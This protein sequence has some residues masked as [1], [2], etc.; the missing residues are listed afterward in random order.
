MKSRIPLLSAIYIFGHMPLAAAITDLLSGFRTH[1]VT[2]L[3]FSGY[4]LFTGFAALPV[5]GFLVIRALILS[6]R[7]DARSKKWL[8]RVPAVVSFG[9]GLSASVFAF[10][11]LPTDAQAAIVFLFLPMYVLFAE[12]LSVGA[13]ALALKLT[14]R[15]M[16]AQK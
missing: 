9:G 14:T 13:T 10:R 15:K 5:L 6:G 11:I 16:E 2:T 12:V 1:Y 8:V 3:E 4:F 7:G